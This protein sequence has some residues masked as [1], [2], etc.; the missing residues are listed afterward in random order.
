[1]LIDCDSCRA[2]P[3]SCGDCV[4]SHL[5]AA[6]TSRVDLDDGAWAAVSTLSAA[7]LV[8]PLRLVSGAA[9][10]TVRNRDELSSLDVIDHTFEGDD[11]PR[12]NRTTRVRRDIA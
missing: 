10:A 2:R 11:A 8:P 9:P 6:P 4:V 3:R 12:M 5:L 7:G 1:M